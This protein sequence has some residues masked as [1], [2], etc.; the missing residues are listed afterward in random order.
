ML[1]SANPVNPHIKRCKFVSL[2][3]H[4]DVIYLME[5]D[6]N[7]LLEYRS[8]ESKGVKWISFDKL[9]DE[10]IVSYIKPVIIKMIEK[11]LNKNK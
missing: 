3:L 6:D 5:A 10:K 1:I 9:D 2:H 11:L 7:S 8:D 4:F